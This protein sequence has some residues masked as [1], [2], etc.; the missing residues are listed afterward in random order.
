[1]I[2]HRFEALAV[3]ERGECEL[4]VDGSRVQLV[5]VVLTD[6]GPV[7]RE[8]G[9]TY[10]RADVACSLRPCEARDLAVRLLELAHE[11]RVTRL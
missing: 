9:E 5:R 11:A 10:R 3:L 6:A 8:D 7:T 1:M 2:D 4:R